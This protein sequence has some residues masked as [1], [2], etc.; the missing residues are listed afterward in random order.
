MNSEEAGQDG[1]DRV[2]TITTSDKDAYRRLDLWLVAKLPDLSRSTIKRLYEDGN[3]TTTEGKTLSLNKMPAAGT[4]V[5]VEVPPPID[6]DLKP[7]DIPLDVL[8]EDE[9]LLVL[10]KPAGLCVHPAP[11][12]PDGT[13]VNAVLFR[14]PDLSG[15]GGE[16][17]PG[18]VHRLDLGTSGVMVVAKTQVA[19][20]GLVQLFSS[21]EIERS[22]QAI[23]WG[24]P[25]S[26]LGR[27]ETPIA[28][29][30]HH[31]QKMSC[32]VRTGKKA[33][34]DFKV[35]KHGHNLAHVSFKL[36][37]GR[38]HQIRVHASQFLQAPVL[39]DPLYADVTHQLA[40]LPD[41]LKILLKDYPY[42]LL[43]ARVLGFKHPVTG[44][45]LRFEA[46]PPE[47][48]ASVVAFLEGGHE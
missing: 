36:E 2:F 27:I 9:H 1:D 43:H 20:E 25:T 44:Q 29:H 11:G 19:H 39:C 26:H 33:V 18:I 40:R 22:Y 38:T 6:T 8:F 21:H 48:L 47:P 35:L 3:I 16:K 42:Q 5:E 15:V 31:R 41:P 14:C 7:Q 17:R 10:V 45:A 30:P 24:K 32:L 4:E 34:T 37:T 28:R 46:P 13:L 23:L 12:H